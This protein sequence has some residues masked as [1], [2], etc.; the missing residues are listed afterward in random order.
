MTRIARIVAANPRS[1]ASSAVIPAADFHKMPADG[2][3]CKPP[4]R[5]N[6]A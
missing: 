5:D 3:E 6:A 2:R 4:Q 1:S